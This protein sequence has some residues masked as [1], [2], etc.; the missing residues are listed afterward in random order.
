MTPQDYQY[1]SDTRKK[2]LK[3]INSCTTKQQARSA[4][5]YIRLLM[6]QYGK[7]FNLSELFTLDPQ[8]YKICK[9][10]TWELDNKVRMKLTSL[11]SL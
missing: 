5:N 4:K 1:L 8:I 3:V 7:R 10:L 9:D 2:A 11:K 6:M